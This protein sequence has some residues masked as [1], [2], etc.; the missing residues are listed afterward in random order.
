MTFLFSFLI[1]VVSVS[2]ETS[3][4]FQCPSYIDTVVP[5]GQTAIY[6]KREPGDPFLPTMHAVHATLSRCPDIKSL[7]LRVTGLGCSEWPDRWSFPFD[8]PSGSRYPSQLEEL[9]LEGYHF[10]DSAWEEVRQLNTWS[11]PKVMQYLEWSVMG[12]GWKWLKLLPLSQATKARTNL[13]LWLEAM[14]FSH[15]KKLAL[16]PDRGHIPDVKLL[17]PH[18]TSLQSLAVRGPWAKDLILA[19]PENSLTHLSWIFSNLTGTDVLPIIR[20]HAQSLTSFEWRTEES[21]YRQRNA[22]TAEAITELGRM[23]PNLKKLT[24]DLNQNG[25]W[26]ME[27]LE[28][29]G[30]NFPKLT[31]VTIFFELASECRRQIEV[32]KQGMRFDD[33]LRLDEVTECNGLAAMAQPRLKSF[34]ARKLFEFLRGNKVGEELDRAVFYAGNWE[35][36]WDGPI[37]EYG[38]LEGRRSFYLCEAVRDEGGKG[39]SAVREVECEGI[40]A[41]IP[42][43]GAQ[44]GWDEDAYGPEEPMW[45]N[46]GLADRAR[47][48]EL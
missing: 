3:P 5:S 40:P 45:E 46:G 20:R 38:W 35:R 12:K 47:N 33:A 27:Q 1:L 7:K 48:M 41:R 24:L 31:N 15:I 11:E 42:Q 2:S 34:S 28:A 32:E 30:T 14:D 22:L 23:A 36:A 25:T 37:A 43:V 26:P 6:G 17:A 10:G 8:F 39:H 29:L 19:L 18:L 44:S 9:D 4:S 21:P 13:A 16:I